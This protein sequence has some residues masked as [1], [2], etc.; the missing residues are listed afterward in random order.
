LE[1]WHNLEQRP[2][3]RSSSKQLV[4]PVEV[5]AA[6]VI[7]QQTQPFHQTIWPNVLTMGTVEQPFVQWSISITT[8]Q[9]TIEDA[10]TCAYYQQV[11]HEFKNC[12]FVIINWRHWWD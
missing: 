5:I 9:P 7:V 11:G 12:P 2:S 6:L 4:E 1:Q 10:L 3:H 8:T